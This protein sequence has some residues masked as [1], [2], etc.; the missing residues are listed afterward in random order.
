MDYAAAKSTMCRQC[1]RHFAPSGP[2]P[3]AVVRVRESAPA[4]STP[5]TVEAAGGLKK[6][7]GFWGAQRSRLVACFECKRKHEVSEAATSTNCPG[8]SA[9]IDLRDYKV[10]T[11][12]SR[13]I[14]T[15]GDIHLTPKGDLSS[16]SVICHSAIIE[17]KLRGNLQCEE[18][19]TINFVGKIP[20]R[21]AANYVNVERK[22]DV[23]CYRRVTV[24][25]IDIKGRMSAEIIATGAVNIHKTGVLEGNVTAKS[26]TID[27]G[28]I[29]SG[30]LVIGQ[31]DLQQAELLP[32]ARAEAA[33][34]NEPALP[35]PSVQ[36]V[37]AT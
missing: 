5:A 22:A 3:A 32:Q 20:G 19:A 2:K 13:S 21:L 29:F 35:P 15:R 4:T 18:S 16:T 8:C 33:P 14:R 34:A 17:G 31:A 6:L 27:K 28:G 7:G 24:G 25:S 11:P 36:P 1:G 12:F 30:G 23:Q 37:P 10:T 9:H 26:L